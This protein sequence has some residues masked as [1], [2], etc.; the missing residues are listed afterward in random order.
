MSIY[1]FWLQYDDLPDFQPNLHLGKVVASDAPGPLDYYHN[2]RTSTLGLTALALATSIFRTTTSP[3]SA[4]VSA[5]ALSFDSSTCYV[6]GGHPEL[7][8]GMLA[9]NNNRQM[10]LVLTE[11]FL[12]VINS[13]SGTLSPTCLSLSPGAPPLVMQI[14]FKQKTHGA[15][16]TKINEKLGQIVTMTNA[17]VAAVKTLEILVEARKIGATVGHSADLS[18]DFEVIKSLIGDSD[19]TDSL[20]TVQRIA[21]SAVTDATHWAATYSQMQVANLASVNADL[22]ALEDAQKVPFAPASPGIL[23]SLSLISNMTEV[24]GYLT[25]DMFGQS[26]IRTLEIL[27]ALARNG[28]TTSAYRS[29]WYLWPF[30]YAGKGSGNLNLDGPE[31]LWGVGIADLINIGKSLDPSNAWLFAGIYA[32]M[33]RNSA[34][35]LPDPAGVLPKWQAATDKLQRLSS[36]IDMLRAENSISFQTDASDTQLF[37]RMSQMTDDVYHIQYFAS[38]LDRIVGASVVTSNVGNYLWRLCYTLFQDRTGVDTLGIYFTVNLDKIAYDMFVNPDYVRTNVLRT[39][40]G[41]HVKTPIES[42]LDR[43]H[44]LWSRLVAVYRA[45]RQNNLNLL[46]GA[47][48]DNQI[49]YIKM[50]G[51]DTCKIVAAIIDPSLVKHFSEY[52]DSMPYE[53]NFIQEPGAYGFIAYALSS[54]K[55]LAA[56]KVMLRY[57]IITCALSAYGANSES[58]VNWLYGGGIYGSIART[59]PLD[60]NNRLAGNIS[61]ISGLPTGLDTAALL[62][63]PSLALNGWQSLHEKCFRAIYTCLWQAFSSQS[64]VVKLWLSR[65]KIMSFAKG[66]GLTVADADFDAFLDGTLALGALAATPAGVWFNDVFYPQILAPMMG[67]SAG[68]DG[69]RYVKILEALCWTEGTYMPG[70]HDV[71]LMGEK[72]LAMILYMSFD[73]IRNLAANGTLI[74]STIWWALANVLEKLTEQNPLVVGPV[75]KLLLK[76]ET[77]KILTGMSGSNLLEDLQ[78]TRSAAIAKLYI[79]EV[80]AQAPKQ[81]FGVHSVS[82]EPSQNSVEAFCDLHA[83]SLGLE[84]GLLEVGYVEKPGPWNGYEW[85]EEKTV[86]VNV[87]SPGNALTSTC[88]TVQR[89]G[90]TQTSNV[91][92]VFYPNA[93]KTGIMRLADEIPNSSM[94]WS[95]DGV[96]RGYLIDTPAAIG[97]GQFGPCSNPIWPVAYVSYVLGS[98]AYTLRI[99]TKSNGIGVP[100]QFAPGAGE[101]N[102]VIEPMQL[103]SSQTVTIY[104]NTEMIA[105]GQLS[106]ITVPIVDNCVITLVTRVLDELIDV[107]DCLIMSES[108]VEQRE[109]LYTALESKIT[110]IYTLPGTIFTV[111]ADSSVVGCLVNPGPAI[112]NGNTKTIGP[113]VDL[114][115][116]VGYVYVSNASTQFCY[117]VARQTSAKTLIVNTVNAVSDAVNE[118]QIHVEVLG[119]TREWQFYLDGVSYGRPAPLITFIS[120]PTPVVVT[121]INGLQ[122]C[123]VLIVSDKVVSIAE[124]VILGPAVSLI[125][126]SGNWPIGKDGQYGAILYRPVEPVY[127]DER[128]SIL[129]GLWKNGDLVSIDCMQ[130]ANF[131][132]RGVTIIGSDVTDVHVGAIST[133]GAA[134]SGEIMACEGFEGLTFGSGD[135][136]DVVSSAEVFPSP[137]RLIT[138]LRIGG[139]DVV[140]T[141]QFVPLVKMGG[142]GAYVSMIPRGCAIWTVLEANTID[143][144]A[145]VGSLFRADKGSVSNNSGTFSATPISDALLVK[146]QCLDDSLF[147]SWAGMSLKFGIS[148]IEFEQIYAFDTV[149]PLV[150]LLQAGYKNLNPTS[151]LQK[152]VQWGAWGIFDALLKYVPGMDNAEDIERFINTAAIGKQMNYGCPDTK[153]AIIRAKAVPYACSG[154]LESSGLNDAYGTVDVGGISMRALYS[155]NGMTLSRAPPLFGSR[156]SWIPI[157]ESP[158]YEVGG[159]CSLPAAWASVKA[160]YLDFPSV[161]ASIVINDTMDRP[162]D[163]A[164]GSAIDLYFTG[165]YDS[166]SSVSS[167]MANSFLIQDPAESYQFFLHG[168]DDGHVQYPSSAVNRGL[169]GCSSI[170]FASYLGNA[171]GPALDPASGL[172]I[173]NLAND[174]LVISIDPDGTLVPVAM[175]SIDLLL[176]PARPV[177]LNTTNATT[178]ALND[179]YYALVQRM[180]NYNSLAAPCISVRA[181]IAKDADFDVANYALWQVSATS[182]FGPSIKGLYPFDVP[183]FEAP[184]GLFQPPL[185]IRTSSLGVQQ[186]SAIL[187]YPTVTPGENVS[188]NATG[189]VPIPDVPVFRIDAKAGTRLFMF[190]DDPGKIWS[191]AS[192]TR[193]EYELAFLKVPGFL[194][195]GRLTGTI[196]MINSNGG[197][198]QLTLVIANPLILDISATVSAYPLSVSDITIGSTSVPDSAGMDPNNALAAMCDVPFDDFTVAYSNGVV[199]S[200]AVDWGDSVSSSGMY[201]ASASDSDAV[202]FVRVDDDLTYYVTIFNEVNGQYVFVGSFAAKRSYKLKQLFVSGSATIRPISSSIN[203]DRVFNPFSALSLMRPMGTLADVLDVRLGP[204]AEHASRLAETDLFFGKARGLPIPN[205]YFVG[206]NVRT[207][208]DTDRWMIIKYDY[209][210]IPDESTDV[211][212]ID[213]AD[214]DFTRLPDLVT[215]GNGPNRGNELIMTVSVG[216]AI[217]QTGMFRPISAWARASGNSEQLN[218]EER[219]S[220][221]PV[222]QSRCDSFTLAAQNLNIGSSVLS[223][224]S[225]YLDRVNGGTSETSTGSRFYMHV[226]S[227]GFHDENGV[228]V[229]GGETGA[230]AVALAGSD[231]IDESVSGLTIIDGRLIPTSDGGDVHVKRGV[232]TKQVYVPNRIVSVDS[233]FIHLAIPV[234]CAYN[235]IRNGIVEEHVRYVTRIHLG[236]IGGL[237]SAGFRFFGSP[238]QMPSEVMRGKRRCEMVGMISAAAVATVKCRPGLGILTR[239]AGNVTGAVSVYDAYVRGSVTLGDELE[240][241]L[242]GSLR[243]ALVDGALELGTFWTGSAHG[244]VRQHQ[245]DG[246]SIATA[247]ADVTW[248]PDTVLVHAGSAYYR[249]IAPATF[250]LVNSRAQMNSRYASFETYVFG[251]KVATCSGLRARLANPFATSQWDGPYI[252][253]S[254]IHFDGISVPLTFASNQLGHVGSVNGMGWNGTAFVC[255]GRLLNTVGLNIAPMVTGTGLVD[256]L[257][258]DP[259]S[260]EPQIYL[261]HGGITKRIPRHLMHF[262]GTWNPETSSVDTLQFDKIY[263]VIGT[264]GVYSR[265]MFVT[266]D[267]GD[268]DSLESAVVVSAVPGWIVREVVCDTTS[269]RLSVESFGVTQMRFSGIYTDPRMAALA[270]RTTRFPVQ[271]N[272]GRPEL[273]FT[274]RI[275][276]GCAGGHPAMSLASI[277]YSSPELTGV[278]APTFGPNWDLS[279]DE[280]IM[281]AIRD[282]DIVKFRRLIR[283]KEGMF[284]TRFLSHASTSSHAFPVVD[285][286]G[287]WSCVAIDE[288]VAELSGSSQTEALGRS[289]TLIAT[290][291]FGVYGLA[292]KYNSESA[293]AFMQ[294]FE[295]ICKICDVPV[296]EIA[297]FLSISSNI[298]MPGLISKSLVSVPAPAGFGFDGD[299]LSRSLLCA[300]ERIAIGLALDR[301]DMDEPVAGTRISI[302]QLERHLK[303]N[304]AWVS[305]GV[306]YEFSAPTAAPWSFQSHGG[307]L[308][309]HY[310]LFRQG[311]MGANDPGTPITKLNAPP[312]LIGSDLTGAGQP[313]IELLDY[314]D[315]AAKLSEMRTWMVRVMTRIAFK[316]SVAGIIST[317]GSSSA[318]LKFTYSWRRRTDPLW[319]F[320]WPRGAINGRCASFVDCTASG[321]VATSDIRPTLPSVPINMS[322]SAEWS[323]FPN[324]SIDVPG[325]V[326]KDGVAYTFTL[327]SGNLKMSVTGQTQTW[328]LPLPANVTSIDANGNMY[329]SVNAVVVPAGTLVSLFGSAL[330]TVRYGTIPGGGHIHVT[331]N[332]PIELDPT[333]NMILS[334]W[335]MTPPTN[336]LFSVGG[337]LW[338]QSGLTSPL[339]LSNGYI[340]LTISTKTCQT[341]IGGITGPVDLLNVSIGSTTVSLLSII[342]QHDIYIYWPED[343]NSAYAAMVMPYG[344]A[345]IDTV[346]KILAVWSPYNM[347]PFADVMPC[348]GNMRGPLVDTESI[349]AAFSS[350]VSYGQSLGKTITRTTRYS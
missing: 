102:I 293:L 234:P 297:L 343:L 179:A 45:V 324:T 116:S 105:E 281:K 202:I 148:S 306:T 83:M 240:N 256:G 185:M 213:F 275:G 302:D 167:S 188:P 10:V 143:T 349:S 86:T 15:A 180:Q 71:S 6:L 95:F 239:I 65:Y 118:T 70:V 182:I 136:G 258:L 24:D 115:G 134:G 249:Q 38:I 121:C 56:S 75:W 17:S 318:A 81:L 280:A 222:H 25:C 291:I 243:V 282:S 287:S 207:L 142:T 305:E 164:R 284:T 103:A 94:T 144:G 229:T 192:Q 347:S 90:I 151:C 310:A 12:Q 214:I 173:F 46:L 206:P 350:L 8:A 265:G 85:S 290:L 236:K 49:R 129:R 268:V 130:R 261:V 113:A 61:Q 127:R 41:V 109:V 320:G 174:A 315:A 80:A 73:V 39:V 241:A 47:F 342:P 273:H 33:L 235:V 57:P 92:P 308:S 43:L 327:T 300:L 112:T 257:Y 4:S 178:N 191:G 62:G 233:S 72:A 209:Y 155:L 274:E 119:D 204:W 276:P 279:W 66:P 16:L 19:D 251:T 168:V 259:N 34:Y 147:A 117:R 304:D 218:Q 292:E 111:P 1:D 69:G 333:T 319:D 170:W 205:D 186:Y 51:L 101:K 161:R 309:R 82:C 181:G 262:D 328:D 221:I 217:D 193:D 187:A 132:L 74:A 172:P 270:M 120:R 326:K 325:Q 250:E 231:I 166:S 175:R 226:G 77:W 208:P 299:D 344:V 176:L 27:R 128:W 32:P 195:S 321:Y 53:K 277:M 88:A 21:K 271:L 225:M 28:K 58:L 227:C 122:V 288:L 157:D 154:R 285:E 329:E 316:N 266:L 252:D 196:A 137:L 177:F 36:S 126:I 149:E 255:N 247:I 78:I 244:I 332:G 339:S 242:D 37:D 223:L 64:D 340:T 52:L 40:R 296:A 295:D 230:G 165:W 260:V 60:P 307:T 301:F 150:A 264:S 125:P 96:A 114:I 211:L 254:S 23:R 99:A 337:F 141:K 263:Y 87:M 2:V 104:R 201:S 107:S 145:Y 200:G 278:R 248:N 215:V 140:G 219:L 20:D 67:D 160:S 335:Y 63:L 13:R 79:R 253:G 123:D 189:T 220:V 198:H 345:F 341:R 286:T 138:S 48:S 35:P 163:I 194:T 106:R 184:E 232:S 334:S 89:I 338:G 289:W 313:P 212:R 133:I 76:T 139:K 3:A 203:S 238:G 323:P 26:W 294:I 156:R 110:N 97:A 267:A 348:L 224:N 171:S 44:A 14:Q 11:E 283:G 31:G 7:G 298:A 245:L 237:L 98:I 108:V 158:F 93:F 5:L 197:N 336:Q 269:A 91:A 312:G 124:N 210:G 152:A 50:A 55:I 303:R 162:G 100:Y 311:I 54:L 59:V 135:S 216:G 169:L 330:S 322:I 190:E 183:T 317:D 246:L 331:P 199:E 18:I 29:I 84:S 153:R 30:A 228:A 68:S 131:K 272:T 9:Q 146:K 159:M 42:V 346:G 314:S 22:T